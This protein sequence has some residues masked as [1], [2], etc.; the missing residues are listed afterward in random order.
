M[1][2]IVHLKNGESFEIT[3]MA[4]NGYTTTFELPVVP[5]DTEG[6]KRIIEDKQIDH[7]DEWETV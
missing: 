6:H 1:K 7:I 3:G 2:H 4:D 5:P